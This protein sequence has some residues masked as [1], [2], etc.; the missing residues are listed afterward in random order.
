MK[1]LA[2]IFVICVLPSLIVAQILPSEQ[3][4][5]YDHML[6]I[7]QQWKARVADAPEEIT[8]FENDI[9]RISMHLNLVVKS[10]REETSANLDNAQL[11]NRE[12]LLE[13]LQL[14][15]D[16][17]VFPTNHYHSERTPYFIDNFGVH[18]AVGYLIMKSGHG[19]L[20]Q[21]IRKEHNY[22]YIRDIKTP[23]VQEWAVEH[24]FT[25]DELAWIQPGYQASGTYAPIAGDGANDRVRAIA[26]NP[27][28]NWIYI[29]GDYTQVDWSTP[30]NSIAYYSNGVLQCLPGFSGEVRDMEFS[31]GALYVAGQTSDGGNPA[32]IGV[33]ENSSWSYYAIPSRE[34]YIA[35]TI[36]LN[37]GQAD[38]EVVINDGSSSTDEI[39]R[40]ENGIWTHIATTNGP[41]NSIAVGDMN[42]AY[43]GSFNEFTAHINSG[44]LVLNANNAVLNE[45]G[46]DNWTAPGGQAADEFYVV[47]WI[48][49]SFMFGGKSVV[50]DSWEPLRS[51]SILYADTLTPLVCPALNNVGPD[52]NVTIRDLAFIGDSNVVVTGN[53][54]AGVIF[55]GE[56]VASVDYR[57]FYSSMTTGN[58]TYTVMATAHGSLFGQTPECLAVHHSVLYVG[59]DMPQIGNIVRLDESLKVKEHQLEV[60]V[61]PNPV[62]DKLTIKSDSKLIGFKVYSYTGKELLSGTSDTIDVSTLPVGSYL[63]TVNTEGTGLITQKFIKQ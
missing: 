1:T 25:L 47:K 3:R 22:D 5:V 30:C 55:F 21:Q 38:L 59:G 60:S 20:S 35:R 11:E 19:D 56:N 57:N 42:T 6:E 29:G 39:W 52:Q 62:T 48:T 12:E 13:E 33:Y 9:D 10:L 7:N 34:N 45:T 51:L 58:S 14:Y 43:A 36:V 8:S 27:D 54:S 24:G 37:V 4:S 26:V 40:L 18:C 50:V 28:N 49:N 32:N 41:V 53:F 2:S 16:A 31:N 61:Y 46:S 17:K 63:L 15:A 44:D 23:G